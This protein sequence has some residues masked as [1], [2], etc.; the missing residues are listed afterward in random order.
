MDS[1]SQNS[2]EVDVQVNNADALDKLANDMSNIKKLAGGGVGDPYKDLKKSASSASNGVSKVASDVNKTADAL[3]SG[4]GKASSFTNKLKEVKKISFDKVKAGA[5]AFAVKLKEAANVSFDK[6]KSGIKSVSDALGSGIKKAASF[7]AK[8][9]GLAAGGVAT[10]TGLSVK[11]Y[12][13][14]E[15]LKGGVE[16]L[17][18]AG[19]LGIEDYAASVGKTVDSIRGEYDGLITSQNSVLQNAS[20]AYKTAGLSANDYMETVTSFSASLKQSFDQTPEG[21]KAAGEAADKAIIAMADNANKMGT[22]MEAIQDAYQGFA[23]QNY[24][25]LDNLKL[26]Y[27]GTKTEMERLL[28]DAQKFSGV[29]YDINNLADVF[30]AI[31]VIQ[32]KLGITGT[33]A[34]EAATTIQGSAASMKAA[35]GNLLTAFVTGGDNFDQCITNMIDSAKTFGKNVLP[36]I[37]GALNGIGALI[38][39]LAPVIATEFPALAEKILPPLLKAVGSVVQGVIKALPSIIKSLKEELPGIIKELVQAVVDTFGDSFPIIKSFGSLIKNCA[40]SIGKA[41]PFI[42]GAVLAFKGFSI[43]KT[44]AGH[45]KSFMSP[46]K[47]LADKIKGGKMGDDL[48]KTAKGMNDTGNAA[49]GSSQKL[50]S[51]AKAFALIAVGVLAIAVAFAILA[52]SAISLAQAGPLAI[53]VMGGMVVAV[54]AL[55][56]GM[57]LLLKSLSTMGVS[58]IQGAAAMAIL[59]GA[60][61]LIAVSFAL[62]VNSAIALAAAGPLA[63]GVMAGMVL[64]I[65]GIM[66]LAAALGPALTAGAIGF[67]AFGAGMLLAGAGAVL[68]AAAIQ[69]MV[70]PL[71]NLVAVVGEVVNTIVNSIGNILVNYITAAGSAIS[72]ILDSIG[73]IFLKFGEGVKSIIE[74]IGNAISS[75]LNAVAGI[76]DSIGN[77]ALNAG[78]GFERAANGLKIISSLSVIDLGK[79]LIA[80]GDGLGELAV[81]GN[82]VMQTGQGLQ[83]LVSALVGLNEAA[84]TAGASIIIITVS[85]LTLVSGVASLPQ[86]FFSV[87]NPTQQLMTALLQLAVS[88]VSLAANIVLLPILFLGLMVPITALTGEVPGLASAFQILAASSVVATGA[89]LTINSGLTTVCIDFNTLNTAVTVACQKIVTTFTACGNRIAAVC[90]RIVSQAR[91][92]A[93]GIKSA[94]SSVNLNSTG[95]N[96]MNGLLRGMQSRSSAVLTQAQS[97]AR[98]IS[99]TMNAALDIHSPSRVTMKTG[100][101]AVQG[102]VAGMKNTIP[103]AETTARGVASSVGASMDV[104]LQAYSPENSRMA[105]TFYG[106]DTTIAPVFQLDIH[107]AVSENDRTTERT[108]KRWVLEALEAADESMRRKQRAVQVL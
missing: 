96:I 104:E 91:N 74:G 66:V 61:I 63:I 92:C 59:G 38:D 36:A 101:F 32:G 19:G 34:Q 90:T 81:H 71:I 20:N 87:I 86:M 24:T 26:G 37:G 40:D 48:S 4:E 98:S 89:L 54:A 39:D 84:S 35:W 83:T 52:N 45:I 88:F 50:L 6:L 46:F 16:T 27:G 73:N 105:R 75:V 60:L 15:Q 30:S 13:D 33:T 42:I 62:L 103:Q 8:G 77:A 64:A 17:F 43:V 9:V 94:F 12:G 10:L 78:I 2:I 79:S 53:G 72:G 22:P 82:E 41:I 55:G 106:G 65:A 3:K 49:S 85:L 57:M 25:M 31:D 76:F 107:G 102:L 97:I 99:S 70:P 51:S 108:V 58:A 21:I 14:Y 47:S 28:K 93:S 80:L 7:A 11:A 1:I 68:F 18:G 56:V 69:I 67:I 100:A 29:K 95:A 23:K 5:S 44:A